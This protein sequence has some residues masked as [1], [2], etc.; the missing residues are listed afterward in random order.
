MA[1]GLV[2]GV[3]AIGTLLYKVVKRRPFRSWGFTVLASTGAFVLGI[4]M[5]GVNAP[6]ATPLP[7]TPPLAWPLP[8]TPLPF[9]TYTARTEGFPFFY[10][11]AVYF[12]LEMRRGESASV[13]T[14]E[15][16]PFGV[17]TYKNW[18]IVVLD[19]DGNEVASDRGDSTRYEVGFIAK[20]A[21]F[22]TAKVWNAGYPR[23]EVEIRLEPRGW[24]YTGN[25]G[26]GSTCA[27]VSPTTTPT[28]TAT[29]T[30]TP[31]PTPA[32]T[33]TH[34]PTPTPPPTPTPTA[35]H[36]PTP[37]PTPTSTTFKVGISLWPVFGEGASVVFERQL[38]RGQVVTGWIR[39][40]GD[41]RVV[42]NWRLAVYGPGG[43]EVLSWS[44]TDLR[45]DFH[46]TASQWGTYEIKVLKRDYLPREAEMFI[47]PSGWK[48]R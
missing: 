21:G 26:H 5:L 23:P 2:F 37:T 31:P 38:E 15:V 48:L 17:E 35:T 32:P 3:I 33:A 45:H 30:P 42:Y 39:W 43:N 46:F 4:G 27:L 7:A 8:P 16:P 40:L 9:V 11:G 41:T 24:R 22:Y 36:T 19:P 10:T 44:G 34:T 13:L 20:S 25:N 14:R 47:E 12:E 1:I 18:G 28:S 29:P 6:L